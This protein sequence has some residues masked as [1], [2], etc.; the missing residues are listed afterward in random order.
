M[1]TTT[2]GCMCSTHAGPHWLYLDYLDKLRN[3]EQLEHAILAISN[4]KDGT[5]YEEAYSE[6]EQTRLNTRDVHEDC[7]TDLAYTS[8]GKGFR[9][10]NQVEI[11]YL[12]NLRQFKKRK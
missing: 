3:L 5:A 9:D 6:R 2:R 4:H 7:R 12:K 11:L 1:T 10:L 8:L